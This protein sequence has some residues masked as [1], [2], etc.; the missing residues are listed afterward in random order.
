MV[1]ETLGAGGALQMI[2]ALATLKT[3]L[4]PPI[5][6]LATPEDGFDLNLVTGTPLEKSVRKILVNTTDPGGSAV[7]FVVANDSY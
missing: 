3:N 4:V 1:G 7:A 6:N 2:S 5:L